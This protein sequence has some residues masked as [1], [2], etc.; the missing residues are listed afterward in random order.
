MWRDRQA[1]E[2]YDGH[3]TFYIA[4]DDIEGSLARADSLG[5][6]RVMG[7]EQVMEGLEVGLR[8][9]AA[10]RRTGCPSPFPARC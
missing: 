9:E 10:C 3:V 8:G 1:P 2:G 7:P 5:G 6:N 4:V